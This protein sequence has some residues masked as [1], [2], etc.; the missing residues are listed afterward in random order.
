MKSKG[1]RGTKEKLHRVVVTGDWQ[2]PYH[3][4]GAIDAFITFLGHFQPHALILNGDIIDCFALSKY[5]RH[6]TLQRGKPFVD[7]V[8]V[9]RKLLSRCRRA[10]PR[11]EITLVGGNHEQ[12][13]EKYLAKNAE[14]FAGMFTLKD[15]LGL[16]SLKIKWVG[17]D[18]N[19]NW[20]D[21]RGLLIGHF[22][23]AQKWSAYTAKNLM[24]ELGR[25]F[26][27][28]HTHKVGWHT[29]TYLDREEYGL[30]IGCMASREAVYATRT[31]WS[32]GFLIVYFDEAGRFYPEQV[33][34]HIDGKKGG[35]VVNGHLYRF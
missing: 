35:F 16:D 2:A 30:E 29:R 22:A 21:Y 11:A 27:Q 19:E 13:F 28:S 15:A 23:K 20:I 12:R 14:E 1:D 3:H 24:D 32:L 31:H 17:F 6:P 10:A 8:K 34:V 33:L 18:I 4:A 5:P 9:V 26:V 25:S 7:E